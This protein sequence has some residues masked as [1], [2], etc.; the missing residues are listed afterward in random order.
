MPE[1]LG[2]IGP[3]GT[4]KSHLM[5]SCVEL[6]KTAVA[7]CDPNEESFY[8]NWDK[9]YP[10]GKG[11]SLQ[12]FSDDALWRPHLKSFGAEAFNKLLQWIDVVGKSDAEY[13]VFDHGTEISNL[14]MHLQL[15][16]AKTNDPSDVAYG[17]AYTQHD[18]AMH[19]L[20][21]ELRLLTQRGK[22]VWVAWHGR[23]REREGQGEVK[24]KPGFSGES[25]LQYEERFL[26]VLNTS[27]RQ[28]ISGFF[29]GWFHTKTSGTGPGTKYF[30]TALPD[31]GRDAK[32]RLTFKAGTN[33]MLISNTMKGLVEVLV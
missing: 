13:V 26:P 30:V 21:T 18:R 31:K 33:Q 16:M 1:M 2:V 28:H 29:A 3:G 20:L 5:R 8:A 27:F 17:R 25:E 24:E 23:M 14:I 4:G 10:K 15:T 22:W 9:V 7:V 19:V 32:H 6:G 11:L 12:V